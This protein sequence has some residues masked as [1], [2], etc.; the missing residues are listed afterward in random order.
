[1]KTAVLRQI[2]YARSVRSVIRAIMR[3][4]LDGEWINR[5]FASSDKEFNNR[6]DE[7]LKSLDLR[8]ATKRDFCGAVVGV[9]CDEVS[10]LCL[11]LKEVC[12]GSGYSDYFESH[13][14]HDRFVRLVLSVDTVKLGKMKK[15]LENA[16]L[17]PID[18]LRNIGAVLNDEAL[19]ERTAL[20]AKER[21]HANAELKAIAADVKKTIKTGIKEVNDNIKAGVATVGEKVDAVDAKVSR[22]RRG[23]RPRGRYTKEARAL[24]WNFWET[25]ANHEEVWCSVN[26]RITYKSV[27]AH[28][29]ARLARVGVDSAKVYEKI[30]HAEVVRRN[31]ELQARQDEARKSASKSNTKRGEN[32]IMSDMKGH[33]KSALALTLAIAGGLASPLRSDASPDILRGG[34][35]MLSARLRSGPL[36]AA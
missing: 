9:L 10:E 28:Y 6:L 27:F 20:G 12:E 18:V 35:W 25:A 7:A 33:A 34:G 22:L 15:I 13:I 26:T 21:C 1:M 17:S 16:N 31:R 29:Q 5:I 23:N 32:G 4:M 2:S 14:S 24:C 30:V 19:E 11:A 36:R 3:R 8:T